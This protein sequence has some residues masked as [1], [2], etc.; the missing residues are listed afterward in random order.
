MAK[1]QANECDA[2]LH[3]KEQLL[4]AAHAQLEQHSSDK[5]SLHLQLQGKE[6]ELHARILSIADELDRKHSEAEGHAS[7]AATLGE[8]LE[9]LE[10]RLGERE[11][12]WKALVA[13]WEE[14]DRLLRQELLL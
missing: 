11:A 8:E 7:T 3:V 12:D 14:N 9:Q 1:R 2:A 5:A 10:R 4:V 6:Q 13:R